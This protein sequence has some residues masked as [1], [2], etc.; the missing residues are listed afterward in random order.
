MPTL[1]YLALLLLGLFN[2]LV[3]ASP[4]GAAGE[5]FPLSPLFIIGNTT[6]ELTIE[7]Q[8]Y[9][10]RATTYITTNDGDIIIDGDIKHCTVDDLNIKNPPPGADVNA[11]SNNALA[12]PD[13]RIR[14][15]YTSNAVE[16]KL[17][18]IVE[19]AIGR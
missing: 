19:E 10:P 6:G 9:D 14:Y 2:N 8:N 16:G 11:F 4:T 5:D 3:L 12:W 18:N 13:A 1:I 15:K 17:N 7:D